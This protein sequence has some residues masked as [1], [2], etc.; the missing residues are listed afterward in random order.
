MKKIVILFIFLLFESLL[1]NAQK[2][3]VTSKETTEDLNSINK[4]FTQNSITVKKAT[5]SRKVLNNWSSEKKRFLTIR[6]KKKISSL[7]EGQGITKTKTKGIESTSLIALEKKY[8][9]IEEFKNIDEVPVFRACKKLNSKQTKRIC[10][11]REM[12]HFITEN[13][14]YSNEV[15]NED[16]MGTVSVKFVIDTNGETY[17]IQVSGP[18][19]AKALKESVI[20][21]VSMLPKLKPAQK[22]GIPVPVEYGFLLKFY[23]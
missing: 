12:T 6:K 9:T 17:N 16:V 4:C 13:I 1:L 5:T 8:H 19:D 15:L 23:R 3:C 2:T 20:N 18:N 21:M 22:N 7:I 10:F 14:K 11:N